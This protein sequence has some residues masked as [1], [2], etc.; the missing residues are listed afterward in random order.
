MSPYDGHDDF[1]TGQGVRDLPPIDFTTD[2]RLIGR[3][4]RFCWWLSR[5]LG[6]RTVFGKRDET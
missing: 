5:K 1:Y 3:W 4:T 2:K 6:G